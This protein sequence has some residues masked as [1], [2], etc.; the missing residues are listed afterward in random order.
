VKEKELTLEEV[1]N[2]L[3][4]LTKFSTLLA[5]YES[6]IRRISLQLRRFETTSSSFNFTP[7]NI[8]RMLLSSGMVRLP[9]Q[10]QLEDVNLTDKDAERIIKK[11][12]KRKK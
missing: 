2:A 12:K 4:V 7:E 11:I 3:N 6:I 10:T 8:M 5:R 1:E 9:Q